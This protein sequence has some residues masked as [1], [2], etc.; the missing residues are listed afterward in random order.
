[1]A[2]D[3]AGVP[4]L[5]WQVGD[6]TWPPGSSLSGSSAECGRGQEADAGPQIVSGEQNQ[7]WR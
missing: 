3:R 4:A 7:T 6:V 2:A 1:M 5:Y